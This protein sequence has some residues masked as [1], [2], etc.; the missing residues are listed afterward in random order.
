VFAYKIM[1]N[2]LAICERKS[3]ESEREREED[4]KINKRGLAAHFSA[5]KIN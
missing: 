5:K 2:K 3:F 4:G 1:S